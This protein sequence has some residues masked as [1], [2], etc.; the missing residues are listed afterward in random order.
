ME[1]PEFTTF[2]KGERE[3]KGDYLTLGTEDILVIEGI[4]CL[5]E[6]AFVRPAE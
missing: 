6:E 1:L 5:N 2:V 4:H 3:Y